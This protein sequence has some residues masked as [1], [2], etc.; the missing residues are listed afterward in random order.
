M[1]SVKIATAFT[2]HYDFGLQLRMVVEDI[3]SYS[4]VVQQQKY[5]CKFISYY[6]APS[7]TKLC[8][9]DTL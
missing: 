3:C 4:I 2:L 1:E 7:V 8:F 5:F 6:G 9:R